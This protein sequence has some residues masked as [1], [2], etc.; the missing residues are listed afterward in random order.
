MKAKAGSKVLKVAI[1]A[2]PGIAIPGS[3]HLREQLFHNLRRI[4]LQGRKIPD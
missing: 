2:L 3:L 1:C 4:G